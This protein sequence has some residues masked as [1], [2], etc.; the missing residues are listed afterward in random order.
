MLAGADISAISVHYPVDPVSM[1]FCAGDVPGVRAIWSGT[2]EHA[3]C[4][5]DPWV[6]PGLNEVGQDVD[7]DV[8]DGNNED[9]ALGQG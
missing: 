5:V 2:R 8:D 4:E 7:D 3:S 1:R 9:G 6:E